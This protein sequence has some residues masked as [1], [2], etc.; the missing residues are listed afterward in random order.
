MN[1]TTCGLDSI[2]CPGHFGHTDLAEPVFHIGFL[3]H[4]KYVLSCVCL[5]CSSLLID[6]T[7]EELEAILKN[8]KGKHR[9]AEIKSLCK[10]VSYCP[11]IDNNCGAP[12]PKIKQEIKKSTGTI[13]IIIE[14]EVST[15]MKDEVTGIVSEGKKKIKDF[16][17]PK[18]CYDILKN[19]SDSDADF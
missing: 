7:E 12:V 10:N 5:K 14:T 2:K 19:I 18:Q 17:S 11:R 13:K 8:K 4:V 9:F 6:K 16:L 1:C 15:V 3:D